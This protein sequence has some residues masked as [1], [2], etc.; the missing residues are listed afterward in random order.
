VAE[1]LLGDPCAV[2]CGAFWPLGTAR[3]TGD[4]YLVSGNWSFASAARYATSVMVL[5]VLTDQDG[6]LVGAGG[7]PDKVVT[8]LGREDVTLLDTWRSLGLGATG[9]TNITADDVH[10]RRDRSYVLGPWETTEGPFAGP[11]YRLGLI[12]DAA[13]IAHVGVGIAQGA[14]DD[15]VELATAKTPAYTT[16]MT[17]D[18]ETVQDRVARAQALIQAG[19]SSL[20]TTVRESWEAVQHGPRI[21]GPTCIPIGL[22]AAFAIDASVQAVDLL[23]ESGGTTA[24]RD[25]CPLQRR[26]RDLQTLR[27][28]AVTSWS[29]YESL[30]KLILGRPGDWPF[31][32]L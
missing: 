21:T 29:R 17:A 11:L 6:A 3:P 15:F 8:F 30:G 28:N 18:R 19:R 7:A 20:N 25:E 9:S 32:L 24:F 26:F 23:Y 31:H 10:V 22:A 5:S 14:L 4:D 1:E 16:R 13:R 27:Q 12:V 2:P